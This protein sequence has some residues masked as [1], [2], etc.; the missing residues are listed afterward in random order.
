MATMDIAATTIVAGIYDDETDA[1]AAIADAAVRNVAIGRIR[2]ADPGAAPGT[3]D[4]ALDSMGL[5]ASVAEHYQNALC[6]GRIVILMEV[7]VADVTAADKVLRQ[8]RPL[9]TAVHTPMSPPIGPDLP[10]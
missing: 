3:G 4:M 5:A 10:P 7:D 6:Q 2:R 9:E 8:H 1:A